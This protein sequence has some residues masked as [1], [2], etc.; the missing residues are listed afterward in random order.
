[1]RQDPDHYKRSEHRRYSLL[2]Q[3]DGC[4]V[5]KDG[6]HWRTFPDFYTAL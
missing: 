2:Q 4:H 3:P 1:M 5:S 6:K